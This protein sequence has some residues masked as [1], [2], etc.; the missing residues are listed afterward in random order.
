MGSWLESLNAYDECIKIKP[1]H[2]NSIYVKAKI[3][4]LLNQT[5]EAIECLK[6]LSN[7]TL[8]LKANLKKTIRK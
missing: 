2:A 8:T 4:F 5:Q 3:K 6:K 7:W 1:L